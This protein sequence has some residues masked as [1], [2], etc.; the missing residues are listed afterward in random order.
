MSDLSPHDVLPEPEPLPRRK[1]SR[2]VALWVGVLA[3]LAGGVFGALFLAGEDEGTPEDAVQRMLDAVANEDVLGVLEALPPSER[4]PLKDNLPGIAD[5]LKRLGIL[6]DD[7]DLGKVKGVDLDFSGIELESSQIGEG[8]SAVRISRGTATYRVTPRDLPLGS[9]F[10][11]LTGEELPAEP[12]TGTSSIDPTDSQDSD[13]VAAIKENG[14]WYV[15]VNYSVAEAMRRDAHAPA[16]HFGHE[17]QAHG[18]SSPEEAVSQ[19]VRAVVGLDAQ[20]AVEL[21]PPDEGRV[22]RDYAPLFLDDA[23]RAATD[24]GFHVDVKR[25]DLDADRSGSHAV[26]AIKGFDAAY[27]YEDGTNTGTVSYDGRCLTYGGRAV[28]PGEGRVCPDDAGGPE[29][30]TNIAS[31]LPAQGIVVVE[32]DGQ[33][34]VSPTRT[35]LESLLGV[36][37]TVQRSDLDG[38]RDF[39]GGTTI[40]SESS[41][42][43]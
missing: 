11:E 3:L 41:Y 5:E 2:L 33:W 40:D 14:R 9:F 34:Y 38:L 6:S 37:K 35:V 16:P 42:A 29:A 19:M 22:V 7:F 32:R 43:D 39:F 12:E 13:P 1:P 31:R 30:L 21:L 17:L 28:A 4:D 23:K 10:R 15:S 18:A 25:L 26:V 20:R 36:L 8:V 27:T 24:A